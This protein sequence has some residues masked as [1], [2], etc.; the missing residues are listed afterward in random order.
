M[1]MFKGAAGTALF[2]EDQTVVEGMQAKFPTYADRY[3]S[4]FSSLPLHGWMNTW[5]MG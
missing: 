5:M 2:F 4:P 1:A 3:V